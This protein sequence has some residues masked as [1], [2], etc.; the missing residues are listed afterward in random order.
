MGDK[1]IN[2]YESLFNVQQNIRLTKY[3]K[4]IKRRRKK[5]ELSNHSSSTIL[6]K[7]MNEKKIK[8]KFEAKIDAGRMPKYFK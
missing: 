6:Y 7:K 8:G 5:R 1:E 4:N 3:L 2:N